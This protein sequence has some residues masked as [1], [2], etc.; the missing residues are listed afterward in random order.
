MRT[1]YHSNRRGFQTCDP[2]KRYS[3]LSNV[4]EVM[5]HIGP[6]LYA[7]PGPHGE[8]LL[9]EINNLQTK[10]EQYSDDIKQDAQADWLT[11]FKVIIESQRRIKWREVLDI[12]NISKRT[13]DGWKHRNLPFHKLAQ[14][15][16]ILK[17]ADF[18]NNE[19]RRRMTIN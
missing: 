9:W 8:V 12:L 18:Y 14:M 7:T 1:K 6:N 16:T 3:G 5:V 10:A 15:L 2:K 13:W 11:E 17:Q 19:S 4:P